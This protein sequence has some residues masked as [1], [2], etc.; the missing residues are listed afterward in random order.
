MTKL[1][2]KDSLKKKK[3]KEKDNMGSRNICKEEK[4]KHE[5][6]KKKKKKWIMN[7]VGVFF[8]QVDKKCAKRVKSILNQG[9]LFIL[10]QF[11]KK[12]LLD[13]VLVF[14]FILYFFL[15][16]MAGTTHWKKRLAHAQTHVDLYAYA[17]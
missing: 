5:V 8:F 6:K 14:I 7:R 9:L 3:K 13:T 12:Y 15:E 2:K 16:R 4:Q 10:L 1:G 11:L 17:R